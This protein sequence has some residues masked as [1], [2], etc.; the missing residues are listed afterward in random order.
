MATLRAERAQLFGYPSHAAY[1]VADQTAK[2]VDAVEEML[3]KLSGPATANARREAEALTEQAG[4]PIE[5]WDW[6]FYAEQVRKARYDFDETEMRPYLELEPGHPR[7]G[8]PGRHR[9]LRDHLRRA[10]PT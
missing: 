1:A 6:P 2:T 7:R 4:F 10:A 8:V 3:A 5:P 9:A